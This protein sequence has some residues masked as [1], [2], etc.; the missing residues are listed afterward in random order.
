MIFWIFTWVIAGFVGMAF[1]EA[2]IEGKYPWAGAQVGWNVKLTDRVTV[3]AYHFWIYVMLAFFLSLPLVVNGW[4]IELFGVILS[5][6]AIGFIIE[7]FVWFLV[8]PFYSL[9]KFNEK[10]VYWYP[11]IGFGKFKIPL[12]Y[13]V[14]VIVSISS[15]YFFW[16]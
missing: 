12:F 8:N 4:S 16:K 2:Y 10:D 9:R 1:W 14:G 11:W 13:V 15:W 5:A 3:T 6:F 7:D